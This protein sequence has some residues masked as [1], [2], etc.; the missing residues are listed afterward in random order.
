MPCDVRIVLAVD[1]LRASALG[2]YG[3][4]WR[5][6]PAFDR[7]ASR[8]CLVEWAFARTS[9]PQHIYDVTAAQQALWQTSHL[10][11]DEPGLWKHDVVSQFQASTLLP[12]LS[13]D[14]PAATVLDTQL[15]STFAGFAQAVEAMDFSAGPQLL[16][17]HCQGLAGPWDAPAEL[18]AELVDEDDPMPAAD[19]KPPEA[20]IDRQANP[21]GVFAAACRYAAQ[22]VVLDHCLG[23]LLDVLQAKYPDGNY[24]FALL[25]VRGFSLGEHGRIGLQEAGAYSESRHLPF[26]TQTLDSTQYGRISEGLYVDSDLA[27]LLATPAGPGEVSLPTQVAHRGKKLAVLLGHRPALRTL[28]WSLLGP[29]MD[30]SGA[31]LYVKPDDRWE[32]NDVA[33]LK[34]DVVSELMGSLN[35]CLG[36]IETPI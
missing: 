30:D 7:L 23:G 20:C 27:H 18:I 24:T 36:Q 19:V 25:G 28:D 12:L 11:S 13:I 31:K 16:W 21:D 35:K 6:T 34:P 26:L 17:L 3:N 5:S 4:T 32:A 29:G 33:S 14:Q 1:G 2:A 22:V 9:N 8:A 10:V 15:A